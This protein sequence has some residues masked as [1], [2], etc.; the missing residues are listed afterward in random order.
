MPEAPQSNHLV[1]QI[2]LWSG[3]AVVVGSTIGSGIFKSPAGIAE[4]LP[5][6]IY[7]LLVWLVGGFVVLCGALTLAEV[8][9][10]YPYSGGVYVYIREAF[11]RLPAFLFGWAQL[12]VIR[13]SGV[14]ALAIV[15]AQYALRF[16][17]L[18]DGSSEYSLATAGLALIAITVTT[19]AN[20]VGVKMGTAIQ[21]WTTVIKTAGLLALV[22]LALVL[23]FGQGGASHFSNTSSAGSVTLAG[24]GLALVSVLWA[25]DGWA[26]GSFVGGEMKDPRKNLPKAILF[27]TIGVV[28]VYTLSNIGYLAV[29]NVKEMAESKIIA[30]DAMTK[31]VGSWGSAFIVFTVMVSTFGTL[32]GSMLTSP[33]VFFALAEDRLFFKPFGLVHPRFQTPYFSIILCG[34]LGAIY[35]CVATLLTGSK[36]FGALS[37]AFVI[38]IVPFYALS[39]GSIYVFRRRFLAAPSSNELED[40]LVETVEEMDTKYSPSVMTPVY[41]VT[42]MVF[43]LATI[44]LLANAVIDESSRIP[45]LITLGLVI[46]GIPIYRL[47]FQSISI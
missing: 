1:R 36:A 11:G 2:G 12:A 31:L 14:G 20:V 32:N 16:S 26:D 30:A 4:K 6:P 18:K 19:F 37:D 21:N 34:V 3:V 42:P 17:D 45:T 9:S 7:M 10:A 40:S 25:Y 46:L 22:A 29:F 35:V 43:V 47:K 5:N 24:F 27:G 28:L 39:V 23:G 33:R 13:P 38:A 15:F 44:L 41:P 8:G